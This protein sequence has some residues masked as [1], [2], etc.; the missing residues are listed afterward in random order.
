MCPLQTPDG[1]YEIDSEEVAAAET[2][3]E[4]DEVDSAG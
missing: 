3:G 4:A 1:L 2:G